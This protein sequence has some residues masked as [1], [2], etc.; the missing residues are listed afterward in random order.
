MQDD[1]REIKCRRIVNG[2]A[3]GKI[4]FSEKPI[5]FLAM[6]DLTTGKINDE[7]HPLFNISIKDKILIFPH[8]VGSS[9]GAYSIF[10]LK[11]NKTAPKA[12]ICTSKT[13]IITASGCAISNIPMMD[14]PEI[15]LSEII[16][17]VTSI[18]VNSNDS[19]II[20]FDDTIE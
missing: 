11:Y 18:I 20:L 3:Y 4:I 7:N 2:Y 15:D 12:I 19:K 6:I 17:N 14:K 16:H 1:M 10:S 9:V 8:G 5:N 13:D